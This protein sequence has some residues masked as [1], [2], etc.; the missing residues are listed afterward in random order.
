M[1]I[2]FTG[3]QS[4]GK[5]TLIEALKSNDLIKNKFN[6]IESITRKIKAQ[7][8]LINE[9]GNDQTQLAMLRGHLQL[10]SENRSKDCVADRC[11]IDV[12]AY[13]LYLFENHNVSAEVAGE[14]LSYLLDTVT[15]DNNY[16][17]IFYLTPE[18][19]IVADGTRSES[20]VFRDRVAAIY[21]ML[22]SMI[23]MQGKEVYR[24]SGSVEER[25]EAAYK[26]LRERGVKC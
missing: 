20:V 7:G 4:T 23:E 3:A 25:K 6:F 1:Y 13:T 12:C 18:F 16:D 9:D 17:I 19:D 10:L 24:L 5:S 26:V 14:V 8:F 21:E 15:F 11:L 22:I 2:A